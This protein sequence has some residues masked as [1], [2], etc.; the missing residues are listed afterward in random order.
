MVSHLFN[1]LF[2]F[3]SVFFFFFLIRIPL[4][5]T[6]M[7]YSLISNE[8]TNDTTDIKISQPRSHGPLSSS[9]ED[10]GNEVENISVYR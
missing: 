8:L 4:Y 5:R 9:L 3:F 6:N 2:L 10:P 7:H 1:K